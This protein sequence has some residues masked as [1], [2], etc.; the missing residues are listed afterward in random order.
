MTIFRNI[1]IF[2]S[3]V[4][5]HHRLLGIYHKDLVLDRN[6]LFRFRQGS[7]LSE[8]CSDTIRYMMKQLSHSGLINYVDDL[9][10]GLPSEIHAAHNNVLD[11]MA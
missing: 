10:S 6:L 2:S 8:R 5:L 4:I 9:M 7:R 3:H 1:F 11:I